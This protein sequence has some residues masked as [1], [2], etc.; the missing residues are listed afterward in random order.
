MGFYL[1]GGAYATLS[2]HLNLGLMFR[3]S[4]ADVD[5]FDDGVGAGGEHIGLFIG[6]HF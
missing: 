1:S 5:L 2:Q 6:Y 4:K 3:I